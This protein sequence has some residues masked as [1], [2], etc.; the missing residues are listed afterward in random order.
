[1]PPCPFDK[2][3]IDIVENFPVALGGRV[4]LIVAIDY[5]S[6]WAEAV[7]V[8]KINEA[9]IVKFIKRNICCRFGIPRILVFDNRT[10]FSGAEITEWCQEMGITRRFVSVV[11]P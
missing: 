10:H 11:Q 1:M 2:W 7:V 3:G 4:F 9:A 5:F 8:A 6:K